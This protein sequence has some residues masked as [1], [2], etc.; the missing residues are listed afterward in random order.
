MSGSEGLQF[1]PD[2][3]RWGRFCAV[4]VFPAIR[5]AY[6]GNDTLQCARIARTVFK[7]VA[8]L[9][10]L[11]NFSALCDKLGG[12]GARYGQKKFWRTQ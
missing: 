6:R 1:E 5:S 8:E 9:D 4:Y 7:I 3:G 10:A 11:P 2:T 12:K